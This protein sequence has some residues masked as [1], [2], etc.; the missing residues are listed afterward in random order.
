VEAGT[1]VIVV[2]AVAATVLTT[3]FQTP[4]VRALRPATQWLHRCAAHILFVCERSPS[5]V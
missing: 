4:I 1:F 3:V 5:A 2:V